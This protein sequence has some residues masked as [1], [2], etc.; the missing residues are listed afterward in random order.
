MSD[1]ASSLPPWASDDRGTLSAPSRLNARIR[2]FLAS[3]LALGAVACLSACSGGGTSGSAPPPTTAS[4]ATAPAANR[5]PT[6]ARLIAQVRPSVVRVTTTTCEGQ[7]VGSGFILG[8]RFV[9]TVFHVVDGASDITI[10]T[11]AGA[12]SVATVVG[13]D[14]DRDLALLRAN[15]SFSGRVLR[16]ANTATP[17]GGD[18]VA[19]GFPLGLPF[20]ATKGTITGLHR[21]IDVEGTRYRDLL[22]TDAPVNPGNSGGPILNTEG[23][24][25][26]MVVAGGPGYDGIGFGIPAKRAES[27]LRAWSESPSPTDV[28]GDCGTP[29]PA[30]ESAPLPQP[31]QTAPAPQEVSLAQAR[32]LVDESFARIVAGDYAGGLD[33]ALTALPVLEA[34]G[35]P[36]TGNALYNAGKAYLELGD[37]SSAVSYL[38]QSVGLGTP[39]QNA[40]RS[41]DLASAEAC[42]VP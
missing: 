10:R 4:A 42:S 28:S 8:D 16:F 12:K 37:C 38:A 2:L 11:P 26:A 31:S 6:L 32:Q 36:L 34:A 15:E 29:A 22:Q 24:V 25:V 3:S 1:C 30:P 39:Q 13:Y 14:R 7:G 40:I 27:L 33:L 21:G 19:L 18:V 9:A 35:D 20:T 5:A 17:V 41:A 23:D